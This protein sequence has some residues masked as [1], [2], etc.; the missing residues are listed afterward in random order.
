M[1]Q[2]ALPLLVVLIF[3]AFAL[4]VPS[5]AQTPVEVFEG[6]F[7][8]R[9]WRTSNSQSDDVRAAER[10]L[11][12]NHAELAIKRLKSVVDSDQ[13]NNETL[14]MLANLA[15]DE[16]GD[17]ETSLAAAERW[18]ANEP[19]SYRA[20]L[21]VA[22]AASLAGGWSVR[23][24]HEA[25]ATRG[26]GLLKQATELAIELA[27][28]EKFRADALRL[29]AELSWRRS[30]V[31]DPDDPAGDIARKEALGEALQFC[32]DVL[33]LESKD[34]STRIRAAVLASQ[35]GRHGLVLELIG[36]DAGN[37][38]YGMADLRGQ[39]HLR[40]NPPNFQGYAAAIARMRELGDNPRLQLI[41]SVVKLAASLSE[42]L[43]DLALELVTLV[44]DLDQVPEAHSRMA[45]LE[46][47]LPNAVNL[48]APRERPIVP[49]F[50]YAAAEA[51]YTRSR[52]AGSPEESKLFR[53][54]AYFLLTNTGLNKEA[55][56]RLEIE[57]PDM[58]M[59]RAFVCMTLGKWDEAKTS[60]QRITELL[61]ED[62][63]S[64]VYVML[65]PE[66]AKGRLGIDD[67][68]SFLRI[69]EAS[70]GQRERLDLLKRLVG[71][72]PEFALARA[73]YGTLLS[74]IGDHFGA[75]QQFSEAARVWPD[76]PEAQLGLAQSAVLREHF[77]EARTAVDSLLQ[78]SPEHVEGK[79]LDEHLDRIESGAITGG[80][81]ALWRR[82][83][84]KSL[85]AENRASH[86]NNALELSPV[87][88]EALADRAM[89]AGE[90]G[91][92]RGAL[93]FAR[94][95]IEAATTSDQISIAEA[96]AADAAA[97]DGDW[98]A[99]VAHY[100]RAVEHEKNSQH[101]KSALLHLEATAH[102][103]AGSH[104]AADEAMTRIIRE[105]LPL[106]ALVPSS[107]AVRQL[108]AAPA[109]DATGEI[110]PAPTWSVGHSAEFTFQVSLGKDGETANDDDQQS[111]RIGMQAIGTPTTTGLH[112]LEVTVLEATAAG[113]DNL[114]FTV[115]ISP[116]F[117][118]VELPEE[119]AVLTAEAKGLVSLL[120]HALCEACSAGPGTA[121]VA[122]SLIWSR[123]NV[124]GL[125][126]LQ[127]SAEASFYAPDA[128][129]GGIMFRHA[130]ADY[131]DVVNPRARWT[132]R[133]KLVAAV[134][135]AGEGR[136]LSRVRIRH[137]TRTIDLD[138]PEAEIRWV[139]LQ[140]TRN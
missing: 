59:V 62:N 128:T 8:E 92:I 140:L 12:L 82:A 137:E 33:E 116:W 22:R 85:S 47:Y 9:P 51:A 5:P 43:A 102:A 19:L 119:V 91:D 111:M 73:F 109:S 40:S 79:R 16:I 60:F 96:A 118:L 77:E 120:I 117:G 89:V 133:E 90:M 39:S 34:L 87:F 68:D 74:E 94:R 54:R 17:A 114:T 6:G 45:L 127:D 1:H 64:P 50:C 7:A 53:E 101:R 123:K 49:Q 81:Y 83:Q 4:A 31:T 35:L 104:R 139:D 25:E 113:L 69:R 32:M 48:D 26:K 41:H 21:A 20:K 72:A 15:L 44:R 58:V 55:L 30:L 3:F 98:P 124:P 71:R 100:R 134:E 95:A 75:Y 36:P 138:K 80:A 135:L 125:M 103:M 99:A 115:R 122:T 129:G 13:T 110:Q 131:R 42:E 126:S 11:Y 56:A 121:P 93:L 57:L 61:P 10:L 2:R 105:R 27:T 63:R 66:I 76:F 78:L 106:P 24:S 37:D 136:S 28:E 14:E 130:V 86:L 52:G 112:E 108:P 38:T 88:P 107:E 70:L 18:L 84:S 65:I 23:S 29:R 97:L 67:I 46:A 132:P